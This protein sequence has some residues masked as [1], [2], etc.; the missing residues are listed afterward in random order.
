MIERETLFLSNITV[1]AHRARGLNA[2]AVN[3]LAESIKKIGLQTPISVRFDEPRGDVVLVA[4]LHRLEAARQ[5]GWDAIEAVYTEGSADDARMWEIAEN[6]H[7]ADLTALER[8]EHVA[9]W[10]SLAERVSSQAAT[11]PQ[12]GRPESGAR[13]AA[14]ELGIDKDD[15]HR[16]AK[17]AGLEP[18]AK[19]A[20]RDAGLADNRTA[21]L[22]AAK[23]PPEQQAAAIREYQPAPRVKPAPVPLNDLETEE[24]WKAAIMRVWNRGAAEWRERFIESVD[25]P[26]FDNTRAA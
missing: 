22:H 3:R 6:L 23:Q 17:V 1:P 21:L 4:G 16:A 11:K 8:D 26:V 24:V 19:Q 10:I 13:K 9:E 5:L 12:G 15:A 18:E 2:D 7:R 14:R 20:A 25:Q